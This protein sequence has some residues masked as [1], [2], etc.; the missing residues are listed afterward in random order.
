MKFIILLAL[1]AVA[2]AKP[3]TE[4]QLI[5]GQAIFKKC[6]DEIKISP[7]TAAKLNAHDFSGDD[8]ELQCFALCFF[9]EIGVVDAEGNQNRDTIVTKLSASKDLKAVEAGYEKCKNTSGTSPCN[10]AFNAF[11]CYRAAGLL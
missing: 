3:F 9:R 4:E 6:M 10:K 8:E 7:E 5:K 2:T 1:I 11:R